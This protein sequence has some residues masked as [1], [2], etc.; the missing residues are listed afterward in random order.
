MPLHWHAW[1]IV[2]ERHNLHFPEDRF[3]AFGGVPSRDI[4]KLLAE[5]QGRSLDPVAIAHEKEEDVSAVDG[6]GLSQSTPSWKSRRR[7]TAKS[8]WPLRR[9]ALKKSLAW[10]STI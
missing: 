7:T 8:R 1:Q 3:Y 2:T 10:C 4:L 6:T 5:E 9:A